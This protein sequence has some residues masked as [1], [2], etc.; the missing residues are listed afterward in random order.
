[1]KRLRAS[2][3]LAAF[4]M[5]ALLLLLILFGTSSVIGQGRRWY[6]SAANVGLRV[7][8]TSAVRGSILDRRG[9]VLASTD[10]AGERVY[11][12]D[13]ALRRAVGG[14]VG[15]VAGQVP[16]GVERLMS[17]ALTGA[18]RPFF[19]KVSALLSGE[20]PRGDHVRLSLDSALCQQVAVLFAEGGEGAAVAMNYRPGE[21]LALCSLP[22][23]DPLA[24]A[25]GIYTNR[26]TERLLAP[27]AAFTVLTLASALESL[28]GLDE[29]T[30][31]CGDFIT[32][33][34]AF[35]QGCDEAFRQLA[36]EVSEGHLEKTAAAFGVGDTFPFA[37][38]VVEGANLPDGKAGA[39][40]LSALPM[41]PMHLCLMA[42]AI[43]NDGVMPEPKLVLDTVDPKGRAQRPLSYTPYRRALDKGT[44][45]SVAAYMREAVLSGTAALSAARGRS[46]CGVAGA[47]QG[48][49]S[50][51]SWYFG[52]LDDEG[53]PYALSVVAADEASAAQIAGRVFTM[54]TD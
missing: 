46:V 23:F 54:L 1:M 51:E 20:S 39:E 7:Q 15:D 16:Y 17:G 6:F 25:P 45:D 52:F 31:S 34:Q 14:T 19:Q 18:D 47:V 9:V 26:A 33:R 44:A 36:R 4:G 29:R 22:A 5:A 3:R 40:T 12:A 49:D 13:A 24:P 35:A 43:A 38:V 32:L 2:I 48:Q 30:F 42:A 53:A 8:S 41:T 28:D 37:E 11:Q 10:E 27:G 21:V 50:Q